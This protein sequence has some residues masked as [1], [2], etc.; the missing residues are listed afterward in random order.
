MIRN[1]YAGTCRHCQSRIGAG[2]GWCEKDGGQWFCYCEDHAPGKKPSYVRK[3]DAQ[4]RAITPYEPQHLDLFRAFPGSN[5]VSAEKS[6]LNYPYWQVS[7]SP[8]DRYRVLEIADRLGLE[9]DPS[10][11]KIELTDQAARSK[12][13]GLFPFQVIGVDWLAK[14]EERLLGDDMGLGKTIQSL[15]ALGDYSMAVVPKVVKFNWVAEANKWRPDLSVFLVENPRQWRLPQAGELVICN[16]EQLPSWLVPGHILKATS[17]SLYFKPE[18]RYQFGELISDGNV[19]A[20]KEFAKT[21]FPKQYPCPD[22]FYCDE[23]NVYAYIS[24]TNEKAT[25]I[26]LKPWEL[27]VHVP[28]KGLRD[29]ASKMTLIVDEAQK[30]QNWKTARSQKVKGLSV[31][32]LKKWFLSGTPLTNRPPQ[33]YGVL[34]VMGVSYKVFGGW[35]RYVEVMGGSKGRHGGVS[36]GDPKPIVPELLRRVMLRRTKEEVLPDLPRKF[37]QK[38]TVEL[39]SHLKEQCDNLWE[40]YEDYF[41]AN[42]G[43]ESTR[44]QPLP[45]FE[46]FSALRRQLAEARIPA[47]LELAEQHE[48]SE[49]PLVVFSAHVAPVKA[50]AERDGWR[51]ITGSTPAN[52]RQEIVNAFQAGLLK[53]VALTIGAGGVG[54]TLT[55][56]SKV[57]FVDRSWVPSDNDQAADRV[58]RI[59]QEA[60]RVMIVH[61]VSDHV[62]DQHVEELI[63][64]KMGIIHAAVEKKIEVS[65]PVVSSRREETD[66]EYS[67]R[68]ARM[69]QPAAVTAGWS[70]VSRDSGVPF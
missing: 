57:I 27:Q 22:Y 19:I 12:E 69:K 49:I 29:T 40:Q 62:L 9:V 4:G 51:C 33:L 63:T 37:Y 36:W 47:I 45:P 64:W 5:W 1:K 52:E 39:P 38:I 23:G 14:G 44:S 18:H 3:L 54:L 20:L 15:M 55:R 8:A 32:S 25:H 42:I 50:L 46:E 43:N 53:G 21:N 24:G 26:G 16:Y 66:E 61:L 59:G 17:L 60:D 41:S 30:V 48:D 70:P 56:G 35:R 10:L 13:L 58:C 6:P 34:D 65:V 28:N 31:L 7:L 67:R 2:L 11:R 68:I